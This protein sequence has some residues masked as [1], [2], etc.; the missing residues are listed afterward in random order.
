MHTSCSPYGACSTAC[1][2]VARSPALARTSFGSSRRAPGARSCVNKALGARSFPLMTLAGRAKMCSSTSA[3]TSPR[4]C[5][6]LRFGGVSGAIVYS[7]VTPMHIRLSRRQYVHHQREDEEETAGLRSNVA[8]VQPRSLLLP[9][10][11]HLPGACLRLILGDASERVQRI[12]VLAQLSSAPP[13]LGLCPNTWQCRR[14]S[15]F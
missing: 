7:N 14:L 5:A 2:S 6:Q 1:S 15:P 3:R 13:V 11:V 4:N 12:G 9:L 10:P 8:S